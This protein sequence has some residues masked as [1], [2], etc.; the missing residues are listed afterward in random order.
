MRKGQRIQAWVRGHPW[1]MHEPAYHAML[2]LISVWTQG[3]APSSTLPLLALA[4]DPPSRPARRD[5]QAIGSV[6]VIPVT[7]VI[8]PRLSIVEEICGGT[9]TT[10]LSAQLKAAR[11]DDEIQS[12]LF[13]ID[14]PGGS[15]FGLPEFAQEL[16]DARGP[17]PIVA[18]VRHQAASAAY[19][20]ASQADEVVI[21]P[22]G[23]VGSIG[24][25]VE[26]WDESQAN[27]REGYTPTLVT[28]S[29]YKAEGNPFEPLGDEAR[30][31]LQQLVNAYDRMFVEAVARG[32]GVSPET[33]R[34]DFGQGRMLLAKAAKTA[35]L[36]DRIDPLDV[37]IKRLQSGAGRAALRRVAAEGYR[38]QLAAV[39]L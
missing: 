14:S 35:G 29:P 10:R 33:V 25:L 7:G 27:A 6:A 9:T 38:A 31:S 24:V 3:G 21:S 36:V 13:D 20:L 18:M 19:W 26:H 1:A 28:S 30:G 17:K 23:L 8:A 4:D 22:S 32:R 16:F 39:S 2:D 15:V 12:I 37:T 11:A 5:Y 34:S